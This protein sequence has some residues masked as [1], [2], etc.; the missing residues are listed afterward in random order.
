MSLIGNIRLD[1]GDDGFVASGVNTTQPF[2]VISNSTIAGIRADI[3]DDG[4]IASGTPIVQP[5]GTITNNLITGLR[6]DVSDDG[7]VASSSGVVQEAGVIT[8]SIIRGIRVDV[9]DDDINYSS[10]FRMITMPGNVEVLPTDHYIFIN[11]NIPEATTV[12][13][14][15]PITVGREIVIKDF[16]GDASMFN[17]SITALVDG[18]TSV[19]LDM[20]YASVK[21][22]YAGSSLF[23]L[24]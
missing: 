7:L 1:V 12:T 9:G 11:K 24:V 19:V 23:G 13:F 4:I 10:P 3:G 6:L 14:P 16:R 15:N 22:V 2:G 18:Q 8:N 17:I 21:M 5:A 20:D